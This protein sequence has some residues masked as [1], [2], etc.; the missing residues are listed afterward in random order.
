MWIEW[1][2]PP[3]IHWPAFVGLSPSLSGM[4]LLWPLFWL[5]LPPLALHESE[6]PG[7]FQWRNV[8]AHVT[9]SPWGSLQCL[10][11]CGFMLCGAIQCLIPPYINCPVVK[12]SAL[13]LTVASGTFWLRWISLYLG[14]NLWM[15]SSALGQYT[16][17]QIYAET[18]CM[19][20]LRYLFKALRFKIPWMPHPL[21]LRL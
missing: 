17:F 1:S 5:V 14:T 16:L 20:F 6:G 3:D 11:C 10:W 7:L 2:I 19:Y 21:S 12:L 8:A 9:D 13:T 18:Q 4:C 15:S